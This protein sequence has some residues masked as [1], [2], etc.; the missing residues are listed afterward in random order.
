MGSKKQDTSS[1]YGTPV[2]KLFNQNKESVEEMLVR[3]FRTKFIDKNPAF[4]QREISEL[5]KVSPRRAAPGATR[6]LS[7]K[8]KG[9]FDKL[10]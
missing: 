5:E 7:L 1:L 4:S 10:N 3:K 6:Y 9:I 2:Q 8:Q